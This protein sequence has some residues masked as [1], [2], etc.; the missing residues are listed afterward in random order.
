MLT[1]EQEAVL[2]TLSLEFGMLGATY[3]EYVLLLNFS[4][5]LLFSIVAIRVINRLRIPK[6]PQ[7]RELLVRSPLRSDTRSD[8]TYLT[9]YD[10]ETL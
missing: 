3:S 1:D 7:V 5:V 4:I 9:L 8:T 2:N 6:L 10:L